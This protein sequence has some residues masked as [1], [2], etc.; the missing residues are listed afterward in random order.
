[1]KG[2][3]LHLLLNSKKRKQ[4]ILFLTV[5]WTCSFLVQVTGKVNESVKGSPI[6]NLHKTLSITKIPITCIFFC[7]A[8]LPIFPLFSALSMILVTKYMSLNVSKYMFFFYINIYVFMT[9]ETILFEEKSS[10]YDC[11]DEEFLCMNHN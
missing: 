2:T 10:I 8:V 3:E 4:L 7:H 6:F 5:N 1:M 9:S 11:A